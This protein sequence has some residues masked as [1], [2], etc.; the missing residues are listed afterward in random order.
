[1]YLLVKSATRSGKLTRERVIEVVPKLAEV[2]SFHLLSTI[3]YR[4]LRGKRTYI[5]MLLFVYFLLGIHLTDLRHWTAVGW[6]C[7]I[8]KNVFLMDEC[9]IRPINLCLC[10]CIF[11]YSPIDTFL[12]LT[13]HA[14]NQLLEIMWYLLML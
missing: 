4:N 9:L 5:D 2:F 11:E 7:C 13:Y 3:D 14:Q 6:R 12:V 10:L 1:M 8:E